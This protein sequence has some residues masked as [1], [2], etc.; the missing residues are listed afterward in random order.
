MQSN[1]IP[2]TCLFLVAAS[3]LA[4]TGP[5]V[6]EQNCSTCHAIASPMGGLDLRTRESL[7]RGGRRGAALVPGDAAKSLIFQAVQGSGE[8]KMPPDKKLSA[9]AVEA[10]RQWIDAGAPWQQQAAKTYRPD[11][12]WAFQPLRKSPAS[13]TVDNFIQQKLQEKGLPPA[14]AADKVTLIRR[15][16]LDLI[17]LPPTPAEVDAFMKDTSPAAFRTVVERLLAS[18]HYG[19]RWGRHWLD[20]VRYAD[21]DGYANDFER[22]NAWRYRDYVIRSFNRDKPYRQFILEQIAGDELKPGDPE[23]LIATGFLRMG[24]WEQTGMSVAAVTRQLFL[25]DIT[26]H[27]VTAFLG[28]TMG[29]AKCHDHKFDPLPTRDYYRLQAVFAGTEF[30]KAP[31][32]FQPWENHAGFE[33]GAAR[34]QE[35]ISRTKAKVEAQNERIRKAELKKYG[36]KTIQELPEGVLA[37]A[38]KQRD[39]LTPEDLARS[40][41]YSKRL[42]IYNHALE[43]FKPLAYAVAD[44][45]TSAPETFILVGGNL[46]APGEKVTP[47]ILS[48]PALKADPVPDTPSGRRLALARWIASESNPLTARVMVNRIWQHHFGEGIVGTPNNFGKMGK[49]PTHPELLDW[50]ATYFVEHNWSV[51]EMHRVMML[52]AAYRRSSK[53]V[54][55]E[56]LAKLD[57]ENQMLSYFPPR[58]MEAE[59]LRDSMLTVSGELSPDAGGPGTFPEINE[60]LANQSRIIMGQAAPA[61]QPSL[62]RR[63]RNRRTIYTS[64]KR[65]I[66]NPVVEQFNGPNMDESCD[67]REASIVP[68]QVFALFNSKFANDTALAFAVRVS[69]LSAAPEGQIDQAY[70]LA[71]GHVPDQEERSLLLKHYARLFERERKI[72]PPETHRPVV[73]V[74]SLVHE[75]TGQKFDLEEEADPGQYEENIQRAQV[76]PEIRAMAQVLLVL[77]NSNE[78]LYVF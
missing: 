66:V 61:Y 39:D 73:K 47:G 50:L 15:A 54:A 18:P 19:E 68:T 48:L 36:V 17:G 32:P 57:P 1:P 46:K 28:L 70:R 42:E 5:E 34:I 12:V 22:P 16:T 25:D 78:F 26:H 21:S 62:T 53:P 6:L 77:L 29:C 11:D 4:S 59:V 27:S 55:P 41:A 33:E 43:R 35:M 7:L 40:A 23:S 24:P 52:S 8:L 44:A 37:Q 38:L 9:E 49:R 76:S 30:A 67:R 72:T 10:L 60:D 64:Q 75:L 71:M 56:T 63:E 69:K 13:S 58:R 3:S 20:V 2:I 65:S 51:K 74:R 45:K 31:L 14:P